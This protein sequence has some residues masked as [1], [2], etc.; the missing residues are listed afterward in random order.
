MHR[1]QCTSGGD[2]QRGGELQEVLARSV[3]AAYKNRDRQWQTHPLTSLH[4]RSVAMQVPMPP[5]VTI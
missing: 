2:V 5:M 1:N 3:L 4:I